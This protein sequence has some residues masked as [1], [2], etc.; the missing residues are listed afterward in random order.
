MSTTS[1]LTSFSQSNPSYASATSI[2]RPDSPARDTSLLQ[3]SASDISSRDNL[4]PVADWESF[5][6]EY[7][8]GNWLNGGVSIPDGLTPTTPTVE[9]NLQEGEDYYRVGITSKSVD[10]SSSVKDTFTQKGFLPAPV[11]ALFSGLYSLD[12]N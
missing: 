12:I 1:Q 5:I 3:K 11:S 6:T 2:L 9:F 10:T 8:L 7:S 4:K